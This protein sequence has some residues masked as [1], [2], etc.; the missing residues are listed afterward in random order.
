MLSD[1]PLALALMFASSDWAYTSW[2]GVGNKA[3]V[4]LSKGSPFLL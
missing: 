3:A 4:A 2:F 1:D